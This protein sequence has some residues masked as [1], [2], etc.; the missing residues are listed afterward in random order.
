MGEG[1]RIGEEDGNATVHSEQS[2]SEELE[3]ELERKA[4]S[5]G[6]Q[7]GANERGCNQLP[8]DLFKGLRLRRPERIAAGES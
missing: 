4:R 5:P 1:R 2:F 3:V 7:R 8:G 6:W